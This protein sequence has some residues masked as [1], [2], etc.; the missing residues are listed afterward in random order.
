MGLY[1][2]EVQFL[3]GHCPSYKRIKEVFYEKHNEELDIE[4]RKI[5]E[6]QIKL[7]NETIE[8]GLIK[9]DGALY[10]ERGRF[11]VNGEELADFERFPNKFD[12]SYPI[13]KHSAKQGEKILSVINGLCEINFDDIKES[14]IGEFY[15]SETY[16]TIYATDASSYREKPLA[17]AIPKNNED[18]KKLVFFANENKLSLIPRAAGTSLSGQVVGNGIVVDISKYFTQIIELNK[19]ESWVRVQPGVV[20]D[21][22]NQF[23][24]PHG[25]F[26]GPETSTANRCMMGGM[27]GNNSCGAHSIIYGS[28]RDH[29][30][31]V[32]AILSDGTEANFG[33]LSKAQFEKKCKLNNL[34]GV[35]YR[36]IDDILSDGKNQK[37]IRKEFPDISIKRRNTG[38]AIDLLL[39][40]ELFSNSEDRFNLSKLLAGSEGTLA[41]T[42]EIKLN[43]VPLPPKEKAVIAAHFNTLEEALHANLIA[44]KYKPGAVELID[45]KILN[46]TKDNLSQKA[47]RFFIYGEPAAILVIEFARENKDEIDKIAGD[48][49]REM[50]QASYGYH[51]PVIYGKD[52]SK[53]W[54]LRKA[55]LG[56]LTNIPGDAKPIGFIE[57]TV[58][59][60]GDLPE[61]IREFKEMLA[62]HG[63]DCVY[64]AHI[65]S[66]ELHLRPLL[67]LK[68]QKDVDLYYQI[69][70]DTAKLVKKYNGSLS[71]EHGDGR[72]R[73]EFIP[74][75]LGE[76]NYQLCKEVK[77][78]WDPNSIF[79]PNK[80]VDT[81]KM[82]TSL[83]YEAGKRTREVDTIFDFS[84]TLGYVRAA[85]N[86]NGSGDC[87]K[88]H[89]IGGAMCPSY[90]A[91]RDENKTTRA[92]ANMLRETLN[93]SLKNPFESNEVYEILDLCLS[94][95]ACKSECPSSVDITKL[96]AEFLQHY[97]DKKG[98]PLR[99][100]LIA[101]IAKINAL[102]I[103]FSGIYNFFVSWR[104][105]ANLFNLM[106]GFHPKRRFPKLNKT[107]LKKWGK[108]HAKKFEGLKIKS[109]GQVYLFSDEFTN[110]NDVEI[111]INAIRLLNA[112]GYQVVVPKH[113]ESGR[114]YL[115]KGLVKKAKQIAKKN[116]DLLES[117]ISKETPLLGIEP[118]AILTFRDEYLDFF[119][120]ET[121]S[122][123][124]YYQKAKQLSKN[125]M[126]IDEF[127]ANEI[128]K[129]NITQSSFTCGTK[130]IKLH[131]H[132]YQKALASTDATKKI[133]SLPE[134][135]DVEE[136][137]S[138]CCGMAGAFGYEKEH[139]ELSMQV[140]EMV[141]FPTVREAK[142]ETIIVAPG[143]SCRHQIKDGTGRGALHPV[144][145][146]WEA[147]VR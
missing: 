45:D 48:M 80:I 57:D 29:T 13:N 10:I 75:M 120:S 37:V 72:L 78:A 35:I 60:V 105:T 41:F 16:K 30:L 76:H 92:R 71:G 7:H 59:K 98:V 104:F 19:E 65:G 115:S 62:K 6:N 25:L 31:E 11:L 119:G 27:L 1:L 39:E 20:L 112:L 47:N 26:F 81:P 85:E 131:G 100:K 136:I 121:N 38:Y 106:L 146:L 15:T 5:T 97:Y 84:K 51:F 67:N 34:E 4:I 40:T 124:P 2:A 117:I 56:V 46:L 122:K 143:T 49:E 69:A 64:H 22:L 86:C 50:K 77:K 145:V 141:L 114:T 79:N 52:I 82:N 132:C 144:E 91:T 9:K 116:I 93:G 58:V 88:T 95:K 147:L 130:N 126:M 43:L 123:H 109:K 99:S 8:E 94:C 66:G 129:G 63:T 14:F 96:K 128:D 90:Q 142:K 127:I 111:G 3:P 103:P 36:K 24:E 18:L 17:I 12:I 55:G 70:F 83:R 28:T 42:T 53:V 125:C 23:L 89:V 32:E 138:G 102:A 108:R 87:R 101:N 54:T 61:Y 137:P 107:T 118:S 133:L 68:K 113:V 134:N 73:G 135:Y 33:N 110:Y 139:Y 21:E 140:G 44:L 74:L